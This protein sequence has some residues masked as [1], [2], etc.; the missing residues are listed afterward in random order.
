[1]LRKSRQSRKIYCNAKAYWCII[2]FISSFTVC[3]HRL[4]L[5]PWSWDHGF[6]VRPLRYSS[7]ACFW[8]SQTLMGHL[9]NNMPSWGS[10][11]VEKSTHDTKFKSSIPADARKWMWQ[12][13]AKTLS[14]MTFSITKLSVITFSIITNEIQHSA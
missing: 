12:L 5:N 7:L 8:S 1:M 6:I 3:Q 11:M 9:Y 10:A 14:I 2:C 13:G 4:E